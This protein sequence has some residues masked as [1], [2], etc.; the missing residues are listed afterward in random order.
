MIKPCTNPLIVEK[1]LERMT[2]PHLGGMRYVLINQIV[3]EEIPI[4][5]S[6]KRL[7][8]HFIFNNYTGK[9]VYFDDYRILTSDAFRSKPHGSVNV[10]IDS[11][12]EDGKDFRIVSYFLEDKGICSFAQKNIEA[13][14]RRFNDEYGF[15]DPSLLEVLK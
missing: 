3:E 4:L 13:S 10:T 14:I 7:S 5:N 2:N 12:N 9:I 8:A 15:S 6:G 11:I 1:N